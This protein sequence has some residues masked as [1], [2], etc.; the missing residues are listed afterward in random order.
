MFVHHTAS[1]LTLNNN[2]LHVWLIEPA[3]VSDSK[4]LNALKSLL[5]QT[6]IEKTQR[7]R[8]AKAKHTALIT[9]AFARTVLSQYADVPAQKWL[10]N[11]GAHGKPE[12]DSPPLPLS[13]NLSHNDDLIICAVCLDKNIGCDIES[14]SRKISIKA[15]A[16]RYFSAIEF[17]ALMALPPAQQRRRFFEYWTLKEAFVKATG[18]GISQGL[19]SFNFTIGKAK[20]DQFNDN[21]QLN[22]SLSC[23]E[24]DSQDWVSY[25]VY[26]DQQHCI[27]LC[28][29]ANNI[30]KPLPNK[31]VLNVQL[32]DGLDLLSC[33]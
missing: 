3:K 29:K 14:L 24:Q 11:I 4:L 21:I 2:D 13:F 15:I 7:Y 26:P 32:F 16:Q 12:I 27:A 9:R 23:S 25:L 6:E 28:V 18:M 1:K 5:S 31:A 22:F 30:N 8:L 20:K 33:Y 17:D 19:E 10:F